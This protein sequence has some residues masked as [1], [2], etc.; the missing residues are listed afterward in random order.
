MNYQA[1]VAAPFAVLAIR[2]TDHA[3]TGIDFLPLETALVQPVNNM[4]ARVCGALQCY[5]QNC[6]NSLDLPL[7]LQGTPFQR[8]VW[9]ALLRIPAGET[10]SYAELARQVGSGARAV[11]NACGANPLPII[12]PCHRVVA[13]TGLGGFMRGRK[14]SSL[15][16]KRWLLDHERNSSSPA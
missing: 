8:R 11:A 2:W 16:I 7:A 14:D 12:I 13:K 5:L 15:E 3:V 4:A 10:V 1:Y 9:E 6:L